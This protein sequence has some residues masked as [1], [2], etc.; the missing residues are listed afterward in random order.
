MVKLHDGD[1]NDSQTNNEL[2]AEGAALGG[3]ASDRPLGSPTH[4]YSKPGMLPSTLCFRR[5]RPIR[6][7]LWDVRLGPFS[8]T[9]REHVAV[10]IRADTERSPGCYR[11]LRR[12]HIPGILRW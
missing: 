9:I 5:S 10:I 2:P 11:H 1:D 3:G 7:G 6:P 8:V 12:E 4:P